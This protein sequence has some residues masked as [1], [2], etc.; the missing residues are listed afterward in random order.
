[1]CHVVFNKDTTKIYFFQTSQPLGFVAPLNVSPDTHCGIS[2]SLQSSFSF[3]LSIGIVIKN[4]S[5]RVTEISCLL[6]N[7]Y[8]Y[9][10]KSESF[11]SFFW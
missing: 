9:N 5:E 11:F 8:N 10:F 4:E 7:N 6:I 1:M 2:S 3:F